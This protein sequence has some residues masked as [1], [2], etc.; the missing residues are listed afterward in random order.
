LLEL[1][2]L[3]I[4]DGN[5]LATVSNEVIKSDNLLLNLLSN[6]TEDATLA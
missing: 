4:V 5:L 3:A 6:E 1:T 2:A